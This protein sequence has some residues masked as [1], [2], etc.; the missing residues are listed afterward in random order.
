MKQFR[1]NK[2]VV[3]GAS[4]ALTILMIVSA[5]FAWFSAQDSVDNKFKTG[6]IPDGSVKV[7]EVFE[8]PGEW[9]PGQEVN[10]DVAV[11]NFGKE[12]IFVRATF[13][14]LMSKMEAEGN[15]LKVYREATPSAAAGMIPVPVVDYA[16]D[17]TWQ[18]AT[19]AGLTVEGLPTG[20]TL[21]VKDVSVGGDTKKAYAA[22]S[23]AGG[24]VSGDFELVGTN[25]TVTNVTFDY[26]QKAADL[27]AAWPTDKPADTLV[28]AVDG[29]INLAYHAT[30]TNANATIGNWFYN[31]TDGWFYFVGV[32][33]GG[34]VS[35]MLLDSVTLS[36][37]ADNTYQYLNYKLT[38]N[39]EGLQATEAAL[40]E[41]PGVT[42]EL[43]TKM[44]EAISAP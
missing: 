23:D 24:K 10:K 16:T 34:A 35:P 7:W 42:G 18:E 13:A 38:V 3:L 20:A 21:Y 30:V 19:G 11:A 32:I 1:K 8:E 12:S 15:Q 44:V 22:V 6:G 26:Y 36:D 39:I 40:A 33:K 14:E 4:I 2:K 5:T 43:K 28:S 29:K 9:K 31:A 17:P 41:W 27:S 25:V 37:S